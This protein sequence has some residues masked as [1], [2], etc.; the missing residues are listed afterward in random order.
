MIDQH[1]KELLERPPEHTL[2]GLEGDVWARIDAE[3]DSRR[4]G[5]L[6]IEVQA[7]LVAILLAGGLAFSSPSSAPEPVTA[8]LDVFSPGSSLAP[9]TLLLGDHS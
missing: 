6:V 2:A 5:R 1:L 8:R 3:A 4:L 9:S 7:V